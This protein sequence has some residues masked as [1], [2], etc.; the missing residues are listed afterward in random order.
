[1]VCLRRAVRV[2]RP[3]GAAANAAPGVLLVAGAAS[4]RTGGLLRACATR[5]LAAGVALLIY[6]ACK[7]AA[8]RRHS[9]ELRAS[10][11][12]ATLQV[13][14][15]F[16]R[17]TLQQRLL[18]SAWRGARH[19]PVAAAAAAAAGG[20]LDVAAAPVECCAICRVSLC[21]CAQ[22]RARWCRADRAGRLRACWH[23][24]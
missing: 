3:G 15:P 6:V 22:A 14:L 23:H 2:C 10:L 5:P 7:A 8:L 16:L 20:A 12:R 9:R 1:L 13:H 18:R 21:C 4:R 11:Q 17:R 24:S 19:A